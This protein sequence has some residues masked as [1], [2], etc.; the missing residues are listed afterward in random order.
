VDAEVALE[1]AAGFPASYGLNETN[2]VYRRHK[3]PEIIRVMDEWWA[4]IEKYSKR[5]QLALSFILW[6]HGITV[7]SVSFENA[8][9]LK[10]DFFTLAHA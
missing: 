5:D 2:I 6:K 3:N 1:K 8:R 9:L 10:D 7:E 4:M